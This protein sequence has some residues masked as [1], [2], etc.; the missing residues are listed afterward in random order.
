MLSHRSFV[1]PHLLPL[2]VHLCLMLP[3]PQTFS[4]GF[5][6]RLAQWE[7]VRYY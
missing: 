5:V 4:A 7:S 2:A 6:V 3:A 1:L